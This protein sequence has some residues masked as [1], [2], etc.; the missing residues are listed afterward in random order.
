MVK[1]IE[2]FIIFFSKI[3]MIFFLVENC[4]EF[5]GNNIKTIFE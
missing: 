5:R 2:F 3:A 1:N 4:Y